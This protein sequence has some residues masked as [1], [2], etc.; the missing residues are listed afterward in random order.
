[1]LSKKRKTEPYKCPGILSIVSAQTEKSKQ[2]GGSTKFRRQISKFGKPKQ[3][4]FV[5]HEYQKK[6]KLE[7]K[8]WRYAEGPPRD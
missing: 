6:R 8:L 3:Q 7:R 4:T 2:P 1:M 5:A